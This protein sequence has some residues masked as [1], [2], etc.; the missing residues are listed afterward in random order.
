MRIYSVQGPDGRI[1]DIE[2][3][4][5]AT[6]QQVIGALQQYL[7]QQAASAPTPTPAPPQEE[8]SFLRQALDVP[9]QVATGV[10]TGIRLIADSFGADNPV[11]Q[12]IR[13]VE[14][15]LQGLLSAQAKEDQQ[16]IA[17]IMQDA[18]DKG[19]G[20]QVVAALKAFSVAP[21]DFLA[22]AAGTAAPTIAGGLA[23][24]ALRAPALVAS[25]G[26][27]GVMGA[28][29]VKSSIYD[30]VKSTLTD[31]GASPEEAERRAIMAQEYG[32]EN[33]DQ[34]LLGTVIGGAAGRFG[35]ESTAA[36]AIAKDIAAK[37]ITKAAAAEAIPE[38]IQG[39]QEQ[40]AENI[41]LQRQGIDV[42]TFRGMAGAGALEGLAGLG[43][44]GVGEAVLRRAEPEP[45]PEIPPEATIEPAPTQAAAEPTPPPVVPGEEA[46]PAPTA[47]SREQ[48]LSDIEEV[49]APEDEAARAAFEE[50]VAKIKQEPAATA[51][52]T[53]SPEATVAP[54]APPQEAEVVDYDTLQANQERQLLAETDLEQVDVLPAD[55]KPTVTLESGRPRKRAGLP[56]SG[57]PTTAA[58]AATP[59]TLDEGV[60]NVTDSAKRPVTGKG[61]SLP[62]LEQQTAE[63]PQERYE[64]ILRRVE[65]LLNAR[66]APPVIIN[67]LKTQLRQGNPTT[68]PQGY[69]PVLKQ[70]DEIL[71]RFEEA[72]EKVENDQT[73]RGIDARER[74]LK[75]QESVALQRAQQQMEQN[76]IADSLRERQDRALSDEEILTPHSLKIREA[77]EVN[78]VKG[79]TQLLVDARAARDVYSKRLEGYR[80]IFTAVAR[81]LN[82]TDFSNVKIQTEV[83]PNANLEIFKRLKQEQK[84]AEYD[85]ADNTLYL[86]RDKIMP[87]IVMHEFVH[88]GT[89]Q[90]LRQY[91]IDKSKLNDQQRLG[92]ERLIGVFDLVQNQT[93]DVSLTREYAA[94]FENIYEFVAIA[95]SSPTFQSRLARIEVAMPLGRKNMWTEFL[96]A[97]A[98]MFGIQ[99]KRKDSTSALDEAGQAF[100]EIVSAPVEGGI[101]GVS[102]L[103]AKKA[104]KEPK[105]KV[106]PFKA[107][108]ERIENA[109][110]NKFNLA[111]FIRYRTSTEGMEDLVENY[112]DAQRPLLR[113]QRDMDRAGLAIWS[114]PVEGGNTLAAANDTAA[115]LYE[116]NE[117]V[118]MP[119]IAKL[120][121]ALNA[122][123]VRTGREMDKAMARLDA[124]F[125]AET[126]DQRRLTNY[127]KEKPLK[128]TPMVRLKGSDK[129]I[130]YAQLR[131]ML[132][133]SVQT[134]QELDDATREAIYNRLLQ[135]AGIEIG[136]D[137]RPR[138]SADADKYAD[139]LGASYGQLDR[140]G[141]ARK[142]GKRAV[143]YED[144]Y[145]D[146]IQDQDYESTNQ[147][148]R[149]MAEEMKTYG[150]EI[151]AVRQA[152]IDL[153]KI[154]M[155]FN[156]EANHL[157]QPAK[158]LIKL[159][160]WDKYVPLMGKVKPKV[161]KSDRF[162]YVNSVPNETLPG[163]RGRESAPDSPILM[164]QVNAGKAA[165]R[166]ARA[167][168]V[169]TLVNLIKPHPKTG[170][171][172]VKGKP[173][174][175]IKFT[176]RY[177]GE[178]NFD[179]KDG[180]GADK[181]VGRDKFYNY[182]PNGDIEVWQVAD[183]KIA[184][185]LRPDFTPYSALGN[186]AQTATNFI[187]QG[188]TRYQPKFAPY[189][190]PRNVFANTGAIYAELGRSNAAKY[191]ADVGRAVFN[192]FRIP[193][194]W[195]IAS[196]HANGDFEA[197]K[198]L[199]GFNS[200][201]GLWRDPFVRD[202]YSYLEA[203]GKVSVIRSWQGQTRLEDLLNN[204]NKSKLRQKGEEFKEFLD[205]YF[206]RW[207]D[208]FEIT[209]RVLAYRTAKSFAINERKMND[210]DAN[211]YAVDKAK[212]LAN[213][214]KKGISKTPGMLYAFFSPSATGAVRAIDAIAPALRLTGRNSN[215]K[216][217][218]EELPDEIK[219]DPAAVAEY[220][221]RYMDLK[222]NAQGAIGVYAGVGFFTFYVAYSV[223]AGVV[224]MLDDEDE[225]KNPIAEDN[226]ELWTR[227]WRLPLDWLGVPSLK[228][229][230]LQIPWGFGMGSFAAFGAQL[231][232]LSL[233]TQSLKD[234]AGNTASIALDSFVPLPFARFNPLDN[235][236]VWAFDSAMPTPLR[237]FFEHTVN[238]SGLGQQIY[239]DYHNRYGPAFTGSE[240]I[241]EMYKDLSKM[242]ANYTDQRILVEP[243]EIKFFLS[244][245]VDGI[246]S[247]AADAYDISF[248][249]MAGRKDFDPKTDLIF[250]DS[251]IG[252]KT[253][254]AVTNF[255]KAR[256]RIEI[257]KRG[258][259]AAKNNPNP[260]AFDRFLQKYPNAPAVVSLYDDFVNDISELRQDMAVGEV[261][262]ESPK[263]RKAFKKEMNKIRDVYMNR[264][265]NVYDEYED[266]IDDYYEFFNPLSR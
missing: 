150:N 265:S 159:Y 125:T 116:N 110:S 87:A 6:D 252:N 123:K 195:K 67:R 75:Q 103:A 61:E 102:P 260:E 100:S 185:S 130:S 198:K 193:Q 29:A 217:V 199:G 96:N 95:M 70:A 119:F 191:I 77:L 137:G 163:F 9:V 259:N 94:A 1:Y 261:Y 222:N 35:I 201:T 122:Y 12:N 208:G 54:T 92:V 120:N 258:Y 164:T 203:G 118:L 13:G 11:S 58:A 152:L 17:R 133:D 109:R 166:A 196:A 218:I 132:I 83:T 266:E 8:S 106:D 161:M 104:E 57:E 255:E 99:F 10:S 73:V 200:K 53:V 65:G 240:N 114:D 93:G 21:V 138:K 52:P 146:I 263:E 72:S 145:Y 134:T 47:L 162:L 250:L 80:P 244:M 63:T 189:D 117:N 34:I 236:M 238:V 221:K 140:K 108:E 224:S 176:D 55:V 51:A 91:E 237:G 190:F 129:L 233:K 105:P 207:M 246:A 262:A 46:V 36:K 204:V 147:V 180:K 111:G 154:T 187:G 197:I 45:A 153:D 131:D 178:I 179:E 5:N 248:G 231:A 168:I 142:P 37:S 124:F 20:E 60:G 251:Y 227:N 82:D 121:N 56:V 143:D 98:N 219:N 64:S 155:K 243:S 127:L 165:T 242:I 76:R 126:S 241:Q 226:K 84:L 245:Y 205:F 156:E 112:Q 169:P 18:Q 78:D 89:V 4:D 38:A 188:Y 39:G 253:S 210:A 249:L 202:A 62:P 79:V 230:Y 186:I 173:I 175:T 183:E 88:A 170:K 167:D 43:L 264:V 139:P 151:K 25:T 247:F 144:P 50:T 3:P 211:R 22:Q 171:S 49:T 256:E 85:P 228:E 212:N 223:G 28:G 257:M 220:T 7:N 32:G 157:T 209:A 31:L 148:L 24:A 68:N 136:P 81:K 86:R 30:S 254:P 115:G 40:I 206:D 90:V 235:F 213:F 149:L 141:E 194:V 214:E 44:G 177:K 101:T 26:I 66:R 160:G 239:R 232:A 16:E 15:Y 59:G 107:A 158:N 14:G 174:G 229:K 19:V 192:E 71:A 74:R 41:A 33:L 2:G 225:P 48:L 27:G 128:T 42:P 184:K 172:Y 113:L 135:L 182:L 97:V 181:W 215:I 234:F 69:E 23:A 216:A